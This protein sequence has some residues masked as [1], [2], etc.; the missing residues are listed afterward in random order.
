[1]TNLRPSDEEVKRHMPLVWRVANTMHRGLPVH[2]DIDDLVSAGSLG[3]F[4]ALKRY[5]P[6]RGLA[7]S[8]YAMQVIRFAITDELRRL[9][10]VPRR[11]SGR[12]EGPIQHQLSALDLCDIDFTGKKEGIADYREPPI[13]QLM[14]RHDDVRFVLDRCGPRE[15]KILTM[16]YLDDIPMSAIARRMGICK[17]RVSQLHTL[18]IARLAAG[19]RP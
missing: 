16:Y 9:D 18:C 10:F 15:R 1:M 4:R 17:T 13:G 2:V 11:R 7:W 19:R 6:S 14:E 8:T 12:G 5:D 3:L